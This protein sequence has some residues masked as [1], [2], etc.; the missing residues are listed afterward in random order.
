VS[1]SKTEDEIDFLYSVATVPTITAF[2]KEIRRES[3]GVANSSLGHAQ[4]I[5]SNSNHQSTIEPGSARDFS[6]GTAIAIPTLSAYQK[7][8]EKEMLAQE[9]YEEVPEEELIVLK[10][11]TLRAKMDGIV[12]DRNVNLEEL[13][14]LEDESEYAKT[15]EKTEEDDE[16][17]V[18]SKNTL[19]AKMDS[20]AM[21]QAK[22]SDGGSLGLEEDEDVNETEEVEEDIVLKKNTLRAKMDGIVM[23]NDG[24]A[25]SN[26]DEDEVVECRLDTPSPPREEENQEGDAPS[27]GF[28]PMQEETESELLQES[29]RINPLDQSPNPLSNFDEA[30]GGF[31]IARG[32]GDILEFQQNDEA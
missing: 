1:A 20:I 21:G 24:F 10:K 3:Y 28:Y 14:G 22:L 27:S 18:L 31:G 8:V 25:P 11:N 7:F 23:T 4:A 29:P 32:G 5:K 12:V 26:I 9:I 16:P 6:T 19:R 30:R 2:Y 17:I 13:S 15:P